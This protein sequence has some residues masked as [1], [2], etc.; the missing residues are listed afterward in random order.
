MYWGRGQLVL[1]LSRLCVCSWAKAKVQ[2]KWP[3]KGA[4]YSNTQVQ[5]SVSHVA[6]MDLLKSNEWN[7]VF[8]CRKHTFW[9]SWF[10]V[11][12]SPFSCVS[13][14]AARCAWTKA[15]SWRPLSTTSGSFRRSSTDPRTLR[16]GRR[17]WSRSTTVC[18]CASRSV[19]RKTSKSITSSTVN[20]KLHL[21]SVSVSVV[22]GYFILFC[23]ML[24]HFWIYIT[25]WVACVR[26]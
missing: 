26:L 17:S 23:W 22:S 2:H 5:W 6:F 16:C 14:L 21:R 13:A 20:E 12:L 8:F 24:N 3:Y 18:C 10:A 7:L 9:H 19:W 1:T 11:S 25:H 4:G 15:P